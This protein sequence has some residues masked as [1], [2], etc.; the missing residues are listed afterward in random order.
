MQTNNTA[1]ALRASLLA[2]P[3]WLASAAL[4]LVQP[5]ELRASSPV[6]H[7]WLDTDADCLVQH[8]CPFE[9]HF[10]HAVHLA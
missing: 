7:F 1:V 9:S 3:C 5:V 6:V 4:S 2:V 8:D 10:A